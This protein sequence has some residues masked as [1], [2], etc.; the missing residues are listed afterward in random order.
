MPPIGIRFPGLMR[1]P[2]S[3][4]GQEPA[5]RVYLDYGAT[6]PMD[7]RVREA[8]RPY[9]SDGFG[10]ASSLY[11]EG[12]AAAR[13]LEES[14]AAIARSIGVRDP[15]DIVLTSGATESNNAAIYGISQARYASMRKSLGPGHVICS[16]F[17]HK[18][19]LEP[20]RSLKRL[21]HDIT[22]LDPG[23]DG[24]IDPDALDA[25]IR[26]DTLLVSIM[27]AN[28]EVGTVQPMGRIVEVAHSH[29]IPVHTDAVAAFGKVPI[30][31][32]ASGVD[33]MSFTS[34]KIG[35]PLGIGALYVSKEV[36][37][38]AGI[39]GGGQEHGLRSGTSNVPGAAGFAK[40]VELA[41]DDLGAGEADRLASMRD[42]LL[43][44][45]QGSGAGIRAA[46]D[47]PE[48]DISLHL[49]QLVPLL[50][51][52]HGSQE[53][54]RLLDEEGFAV[55]GGSACTSSQ[56]KANHVLASMGVQTSDS[57]G[58]LRITMG[59]GTVPAHVEALA[60]ALTRL[61]S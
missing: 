30:S 52:G 31:V 56:A 38:L 20:V 49:P 39:H 32:R 40:A 19:V 5:E 7:P 55:S 11:S 25:A 8:M 43:R 3:P 4:S 18:A 13:V 50:V 42:G 57:L 2:G 27:Y 14:R 48:G 23:P 34:H 21:G 45:A 22:F 29:G 47:I 59:R 16:S 51:E 24:F 15:H 35:G 37:F 53:L 9:L 1:M 33:S 46:V 41:M 54:V 60:D 58:F 61:P 6:A 36:P 17:E 26:P 28:N 10:N 12:K 44:E